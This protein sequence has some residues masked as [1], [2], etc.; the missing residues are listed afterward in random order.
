MDKTTSLPPSINMMKQTPFPSLFSLK[1][2]SNNYMLIIK[3]KIVLLHPE[4]EL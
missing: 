4:K 1:K 2:I 3:K